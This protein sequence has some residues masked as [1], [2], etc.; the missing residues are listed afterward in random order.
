MTFFWRTPDNYGG[1][2]L[3]TT[4]GKK[5]LPMPRGPHSVGFV[6]L[7]TPGE[8]DQA[9][10]VRILYPTRQ[11]SISSTDRWPVWT[12]DEYLTGFV[13]F[14]QVGHGTIRKG[15]NGPSVSAPDI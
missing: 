7:M 10:F 13:S 9:S 6:D 11:S 12:E 4:D 14:V 15:I 5:H 1:G 3:P 8:P 2:A